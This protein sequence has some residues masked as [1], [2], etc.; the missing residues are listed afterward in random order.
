[1]PVRVR[2]GVVLAFSEMTANGS[3]SSLRLLGVATLPALPLATHH[4]RSKIDTLLNPNLVGQNSRLR[5][6]PEMAGLEN[7]L[8]GEACSWIY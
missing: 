2:G 4:C 7:C 3:G 5:P 6:E 8:S 1:M